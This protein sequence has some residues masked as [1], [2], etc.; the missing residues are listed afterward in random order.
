[1]CC[2]NH[3]DFAIIADQPNVVCHF[4]FATIKG[5]DASGVD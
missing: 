4:P 3:N 2:V 5:E 1:V